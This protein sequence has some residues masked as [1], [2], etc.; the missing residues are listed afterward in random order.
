[1]ARKPRPSGR[2]FSG[3]RDYC[4]PDGVIHCEQLRSPQARFEPVED[5]GRAALRAMGGKEPEPMRL[6]GCKIT[7]RRKRCLTTDRCKR[8][9][10]GRFHRHESG[11]M[12]L[13][14][15]Y[16]SHYDLGKGRILIRS[17][18][19]R[20]GFARPRELLETGPVFASGLKIGANDPKFK[21]LT[22]CP[23]KAAVCACP[24]N[25]R[26]CPFLALLFGS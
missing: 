12:A 11:M 16:V 23:V 25:L 19:I 9:S 17:W 5:V 8:G 7:P 18:S 2:F 3:W 6:S 1:M 15:K 26:A 22:F 13:R 20:F 24:L 14:R 10:S 4:S 21:P